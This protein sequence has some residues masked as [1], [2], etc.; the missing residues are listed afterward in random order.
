M[1]DKNNSNPGGIGVRIRLIRKL[2]GMSQTEMANAVGVDRYQSIGRYE[3]NERTP[4][5]SNLV[6]IV[7]I[8][9]TT[10]DWLVCGKIEIQLCKGIDMQIR[11]RN[12]SVARTSKLLEKPEKLLQ[13]IIECTI[14]PSQELVEKICLI[15]NIGK[16]DLYEKSRPPSVFYD[17]K[18]EVINNEVREDAEFRNAV[19]EVAERRRK[20]REGLSNLN[21]FDP[22]LE[23]I[24]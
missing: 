1:Q 4:D 20:L 3:K 8:G 5:L 19:Y 16:K 15:F 23:G 22:G 6:Q 24:E 18:V 14:M 7:T 21:K 13:A 9:N 17:E 11:A 10:L 2:M 12:L